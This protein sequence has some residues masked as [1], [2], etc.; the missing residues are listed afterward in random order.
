MLVNISNKND[1][2]YSKIVT[3]THT[4]TSN[5]YHFYQK[6]NKKSHLFVTCY[7]L[8]PFLSFQSFQQCN[9]K[10][11]LIFMTVVCISSPSPFCLTTFFT[12]FIIIVTP[13]V[14]PTCIVANFGTQ[15]P[16]FT[17]YSQSVWTSGWQINNK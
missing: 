9:T 7:L 2:F 12:W 10:K 13:T 1:I 8:I 3:F 5:F 15:F 16:L 4:Y 6:T 14:T 11:M 17:L